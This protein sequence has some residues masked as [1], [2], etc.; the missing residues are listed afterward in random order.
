VSFNKRSRIYSFDSMFLTMENP[1]T[2]IP[3]N[4]ST[5]ESGNVSGGWFPAVRPGQENFTGPYGAG[6]TIMIRGTW[7]KKRR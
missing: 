7:V 6:A 5:S 4:I 3:A 2:P 1:N